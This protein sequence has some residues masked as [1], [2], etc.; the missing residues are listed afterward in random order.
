AFPLQVALLY[1]GLGLSLWAA[2]RRAR[3][4]RA[5]GKAVAAYA[6]LA[7]L[8]ATVT[9]LIFAQPMV[10]RGSLLGPA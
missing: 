6:L 9:L 10:A 2:V 4:S 3:G 7:V 8:Y 5:P 1:A